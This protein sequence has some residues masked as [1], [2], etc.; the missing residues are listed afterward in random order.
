MPTLA[1]NRRARY[2]YEILET[3]TAGISLLGHEVK[4]IK[5]QK[6]NL[7]GSYAIIRGNEVLLVGMTVPPYDKAGKLENYDPQRTR[8]LLLR[9]E[10]TKKIAGQLFQRGLA[11]LPLNIF[12]LRGVI[13]V[14]LGL[15]KGRKQ[16][17]KRSQARKKE[18]ERELTTVIGN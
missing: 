11:L 7:T 10:E 14:E 17:D 13:K 15:G 12:S 2:D 8:K 9:K 3:V 18:L 6:A 5:G 4:S 1:V 16:Y